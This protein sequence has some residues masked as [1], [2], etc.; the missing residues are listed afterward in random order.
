MC[1][2]LLLLSARHI[3]FDFQAMPA[4]SF[5]RTIFINAFVGRS[6]DR[7]DSVIESLSSILIGL[8]TWNKNEFATL[9]AC[10]LSGCTFWF[11]HRTRSLRR[12]K[13]SV[14]FCFPFIASMTMMATATTTTK[15]TITR[16]QSRSSEMKRLRVCD[17]TGCTV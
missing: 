3:W 1:A 13:A 9:L 12:T 14:T 17:L 10:I 4:L 5:D 7:M 2:L 8:Q 11:T 16:W 6:D 15:T